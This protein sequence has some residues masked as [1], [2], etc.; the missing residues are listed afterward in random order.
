[1][2]N[3][4]YVSCHISTHDKY[5]VTYRK[6]AFSLRFPSLF[7]YNQLLFSIFLYTKNML[8]QYK[9][10][11]YKKLKVDVHMCLNIAR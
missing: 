7:N 1:M 4:I 2:N 11:I 5:M 3:T 6:L 10:L 9:I 8:I